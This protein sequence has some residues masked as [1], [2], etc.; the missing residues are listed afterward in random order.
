MVAKDRACDKL[1][2]LNVGGCGQGVTQVAS[3]VTRCCPGRRRR[4]TRYRGP[5]W[6]LRR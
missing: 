2:H 6:R 4:R 5:A 1:A 3:G